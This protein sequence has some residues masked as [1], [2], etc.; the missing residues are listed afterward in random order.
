MTKGLQ[1]RKPKTSKLKLNS[2]K[3]RDNPQKSPKDSHDITEISKIQLTSKQT[4]AKKISENLGRK[5]SC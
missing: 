2:Q 4:V 5:I 1:F 3:G